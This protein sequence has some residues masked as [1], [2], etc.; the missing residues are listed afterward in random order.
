MTDIHTFLRTFRGISPSISKK[1]CLIL[2]FDLRIKTKKLKVKDRET[3]DS[4]IRSRVVVGKSLAYSIKK[5]I[6]CSKVI[7]SYVGKRHS[8]GLP[9]RGQRTRS[10]GSTARKLSFYK[11]P[12]KQNLKLKKSKKK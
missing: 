3:I 8:L 6:I 11:E 10:N 4:L 12:L 5:N 7:K 1:M 9:T 2:G